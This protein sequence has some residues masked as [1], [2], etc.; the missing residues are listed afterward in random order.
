[1]LKKCTPLWREADFEVN[2]KSTTCSDHFWKLR[3]RK[4]ARRCGTKPISEVRMLNTKNTIFSGQFWAFS[5]ATLHYINNKCN[6]YRYSYK[7]NYNHRY[8]ALVPLPLHCSYNRN[9]Y[10]NYNNY[11]YRYNY[12]YSY[13][14]T[15]HWQ[16]QQQLQLQLQLLCAPAILRYSILQLQPHYTTT[17]T[18]TTTT[19]TTITTNYYCYY[20]Y[21]YWDPK[22][23]FYCLFSMFLMNIYDF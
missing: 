17:T 5:R 11:R 2:G 7:Y 21:Y 15:T 4:N 16:L 23:I 18:A 10:N 6:S 20:N 13:K 1:M 9:N 19:S 22:K 12:N 3:C 8:A 14:Y